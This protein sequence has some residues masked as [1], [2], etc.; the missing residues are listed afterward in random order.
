MK[1]L[2]YSCC[3][4]LCFTQATCKKEKPAIEQLPPA[5]QTGA[6]TFG[7]LINGK[8]FMPKGWGGREPNFYIIVDPGFDGN[9]HIKVYRLIE[10]KK[11]S[12]SIFCYDIQQKGEYTIDADKRTWI[13]YRNEMSNCN[14]LQASDN[15]VSGILKI[16]KYDLQNR[17]IAG[18]FECKLFDE[19]SGCDT[20]KVTNGRFDYK[21]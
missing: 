2:L 3:I 19:A 4:L 16:T 1:Q 13:N 5:T 10:G 21:L 15:Y 6:G 9:L 14:F 17:I 20:I 18:E 8:A 12:I 7:C 11:E